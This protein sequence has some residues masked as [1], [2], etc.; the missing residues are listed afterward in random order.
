MTQSLL[1]SWVLAVFIAHSLLLVS[2]SNVEAVAQQNA[3]TK[4]R[5]WKTVD[6]TTGALA[7][8]DLN[9]IRHGIKG[10]AMAVVAEF[11]SGAAGPQ[12][13][14]QL[15][16]DCHGQYASI[17]D[18]FRISYPA[19]PRSVMGVIASIACSGAKDTFLQSLRAQK[20]PP[21]NPADY[22]RGFSAEACERIK[23][24]GMSG[25]KPSYCKPG[26]AR[27]GSGLDDEQL[28]TC[29]VVNAYASA[30]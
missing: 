5:L 28:R 8:I 9:S 27:A 1:R 10:N 12:T 23:S 29:Y 13:M 26:F 30:K 4:P 3:T 19:P 20:S 21:P 7:K 18:G 15:L 24:V 17:L 11:P 16:F 6:G 14:S 25:K 22:C 2:G